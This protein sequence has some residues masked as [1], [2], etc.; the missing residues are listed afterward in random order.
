MKK[1]TLL[2]RGE[3][4]AL[5][6]LHHRNI[7]KLIGVEFKH[8]EVHGLIMEYV[9]GERLDKLIRRYRFLNETIVQLFTRQLVDA[10]A[11]MHSKYIMHRY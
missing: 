2:F 4:E 6:N 8:N 3:L 5:Y 11:Y 7:V 10:V 1:S 9:N